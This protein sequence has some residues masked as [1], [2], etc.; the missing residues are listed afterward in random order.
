MKGDRWLVTLTTKQT[1]P[2]LDKP[3]YWIDGNTH[4]GEVTGS[5]VVLYTIWSYLTHYGSDPI[6][7]R[8]LDRAAISSAALPAFA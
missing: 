3:A 2:S 8:L 4:A 1:G 7:T 5:T 6:L